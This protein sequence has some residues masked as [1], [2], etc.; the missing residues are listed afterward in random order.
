MSLALNHV[1]ERAHRKKAKVR[2]HIL[3]NYDLDVSILK[4]LCLAF[5]VEMCLLFTGTAE[6]DTA[7]EHPA[8]WKTPVSFNQLGSGKCGRWVRFK[9]SGFETTAKRPHSR[10][11]SPSACPSRCVNST[12]VDSKLTESF[13]QCF[14]NT[15]V[16]TFSLQIASSDYTDLPA[17]S[18]ASKTLM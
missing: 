10:W 4:H 8:S 5:I 17:P 7:V 6:A 15:S 12:A 9:R 14:F 11:E 1:K 3:P 16:F 18:L 2:N 13:I